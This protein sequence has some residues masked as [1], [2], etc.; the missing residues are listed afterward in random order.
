MGD[1]HGSRRGRAVRGSGCDTLAVLGGRSAPM[2]A[3]RN[4]EAAEETLQIRR[5]TRRIIRT[6]RA[7]LA[8][9][10]N[11]V[12][13]RRRLHRTAARGKKIVR[14]GATAIAVPVALVVRRTHHVGDAAVRWPA[15]V[16]M[17][18]SAGNASRGSRRETGACTENESKSAEND[19]NE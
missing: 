9:P 15:A 18:R 13:G 5:L 3:T 19:T 12:D 10:K 11:D 8:A 6:V 16:T 2:V 17:I 7:P 4:R 14:A 1:E